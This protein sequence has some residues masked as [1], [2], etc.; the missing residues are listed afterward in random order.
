MAKF[1][2]GFDLT[3]EEIAAVAK[4]VDVGLYKPIDERR[5]SKEDEQLLESYKPLHTYLD[6]V[7]EGSYIDSHVA[8]C[9]YIIDHHEW[10]NKIYKANLISNG[11]IQIKDKMF[12]LFTDIVIACELLRERPSRTSFMTKVTV[13]DFLN[14]ARQSI[15]REKWRLKDMWFVRKYNELAKELGS[16]YDP[17]AN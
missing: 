10:V 14:D 3:V 11:E 13:E 4:I 8:V 2:I 5:E 17:D 7:G 15:G 9:S 6:S 1:K 12:Y 16:T